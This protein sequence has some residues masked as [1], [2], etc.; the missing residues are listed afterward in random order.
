[1][2]SYHLVSVMIKIKNQDSIMV[3]A[4]GQGKGRVYSSYLIGIEFQ[5]YKMERVMEMVGCD[6][7]V[8]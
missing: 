1:M 4:E 8:T 3:V 5:S 6:C 7:T 2:R